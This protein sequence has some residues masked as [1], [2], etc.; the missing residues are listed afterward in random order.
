MHMRIY[1]HIRG[2]RIPSISISMS[3]YIYMYV[4]TYVEASYASV[5]DFEFPGAR[6][7]WFGLRVWCFFPARNL[8]SK[9]SDRQ[10]GRQAG[11]Q[12]EGKK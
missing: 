10:T 12:T 11:R 6:R 1:T 4:C 7:P 2:I 8:N 5:Y 3:I 9:Q